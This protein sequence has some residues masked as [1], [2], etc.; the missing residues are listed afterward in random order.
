MTENQHLTW[1]MAMPDCANVNHVMQQLTQVQFNSGEQNKDMSKARQ[2]RDYKDTQ[3]VISCL[4][5]R[6]PFSLDNN[7]RNIST[8]VYAHSEANSYKA[9]AVGQAI[10]DDMLHNSAGDYAFQKKETN[11]DTEF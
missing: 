11:C 8:G 6:N 1:V 10:P 4:C 2:D 9:K 3:T 5:D 7:L